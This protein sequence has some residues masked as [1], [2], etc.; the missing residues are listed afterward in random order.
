MTIARNDVTGDALITK[1]ANDAY[2]SGWDRIFGKPQMEYHFC[3]MAGSYW[4]E[5][6]VLKDDGDTYTIRYHDFVIGEDVAQEGVE[7][8]LVRRQE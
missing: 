8:R 4:V 2:R 5:C 1:G 6:E 7:K 3:S